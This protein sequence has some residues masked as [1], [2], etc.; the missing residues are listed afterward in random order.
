MKYQTP[1]KDSQTSAI[2]TSETAGFF[3]TTFSDKARACE[4]LE[5]D[6]TQ[7]TQRLPV[8]LELIWVKEQSNEGLKTE[9]SVHHWEVTQGQVTDGFM[10]RLNHKSSRITLVVES[11]QTPKQT[12]TKKSAASSES[13]K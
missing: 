13:I 12:E 4:I 1:Q 6:V 3:H 8:H 10:N 5:D 2:I 11:L 9:F 7:S